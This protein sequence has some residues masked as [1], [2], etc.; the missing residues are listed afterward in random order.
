MAAANPGGVDA[1]ER[2]MER[3]ASEQDDVLCTLP[4]V[5]HDGDLRDRMWAQL[6]DLLVESMFLD[7][8]RDFLAG[9]LDREAYVAALTELADRCRSV[10][11]LPLPTRSL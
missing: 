11:L 9:A 6:V 10:G 2:L 1:H 7:L 8:R 5:D 4:L 3:V